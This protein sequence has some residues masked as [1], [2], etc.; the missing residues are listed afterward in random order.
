[1]LNQKAFTTGEDSMC[2]FSGPKAPPPPPP[3]DNTAEEEA[4]AES[5][6]R[7]RRQQD[8][9]TTRLKEEAFEDR[10]QAYQGGRGRRSLLTGPRGGRGFALADN[11]MSKKTLGA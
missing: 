9:E 7:M 4:A 3:P 10:L 2:S 11:M 5:R 1:M 8:L 6:A